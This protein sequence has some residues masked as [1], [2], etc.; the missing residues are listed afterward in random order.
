LRLQCSRGT[1][2]DSVEG[3]RGGPS[4]HH[5]HPHHLL[6]FRS[7]AGLAKLADALKNSGEAAIGLGDPE[8]MKGFAPF[9]FRIRPIREVL[10]ALELAELTLKEHQQ[11]GHGSGRF[12][13]L[14]AAARE[15]AGV[16]GL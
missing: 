4:Q 10:D 8:A 12:H 1:A 2:Y 13:V 5:H 15:A 7:R 14:L 6:R 11:S 9:G 16:Q 3:V